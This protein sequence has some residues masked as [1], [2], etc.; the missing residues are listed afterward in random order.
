MIER[1][2]EGRAPAARRGRVSA[3]MRNPAIAAP[4]AVAVLI[5]VAA[6]A[7]ILMNRHVLA[8]WAM[9]DELQ[10]S[11]LAK[12]FAADG[13][14]LFRDQPR[15][16]LSIYPALISPAW[17]AASMKTTYALAKSFNVALMTLAAVPLWFW[18]RR[19]VSP[20]YSVLVVALFLAIPSFVYTGEILTENAYLP[21]VVLALFTLAL[22][23]ERPTV[24]RQ[25][26]ALVLA[27]L[28][29][30]VRVQG[31][32]FALIIPT[33]IVLKV[34]FDLRAARPAARRS[35]LRDAARRWSLSIGALA[36]AAVLYVAY[37][38]V[39]GASLYSG[40]GIY[41]G[42]AQSNYSVRE[43][44]RWVVY[45]F[46]EL[47]FSVGVLPFSALILLTGLAFLRG[48]LAGAAERAF[49]AAATAGVFWTVVEAGVFASDF[50]FRIEERY[51]FNVVPVLLLAL[52]VW[53]DR[54]LPR[55]PALTAA[56][57][58]VPA[59]LLLSVPYTGFFTVALY[60]DTFGLI[61]LWRLTGRLGN[62]AETEVF[63]GLGMLLAGLLFASLPRR[64]AIVAIPVSILAF[65]IA[66]TNSVF[67]TVEFLSAA[68]RHAG[69]LS[70]DP[71]WIDDT[72]GK[73]ARAEF[74]YTSEISDPHTLWQSEF[75]NRS[76]HRVFGVTSQDPSIPDVTAPLD[77]ATGRIEPGLPAGSPDVRPRYVVAASSVDVDG[78]LLARNGS[79]SLYR[80]R[81]P[82]RLASLSSGVMPD[83]W[84]GAS[85]TYTSY[86][87]PP[88][89]KHVDVLLE[90]HGIAGPPP[91][92]VRVSVGPVGGTTVWKT[93][94]GTV[95]NGGGQR[96]SLPVRRAPFQVRLS[97]SPTF[98]P[99][100]FG[101]PDTR[102]LGVRASF[103]V[104]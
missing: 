20:V 63:V 18:A 10:Y 100:Q 37:K 38:V 52:V 71:S 85:A 70:G 42:I 22:A 92:R 80:V 32:V 87:L 84:V 40:F 48:G 59:A 35:V 13:R 89:A 50:A 51:M 5:L 56:A 64:F 36:L 45:H 54:G 104:R 98:S 25:L 30:A 34:A 72:I 103:S 101:S 60:N 28:A 65:F 43:A 61:P 75:W 81:P 83:R 39:Q 66:S 1:R 21:A 102:Q 9:E 26:L 94:T 95:Q 27:A 97:T 8:P 76:V 79:L 23:L 68:T 93:D 24:W 67:G 14:Y 11:D 49:V 44:S 47:A 74:L 29:V 17:F 33:A 3:V 6:V 96:F 41:S 55:P 62:V 16:V 73:N 31:I 77:P 91:A 7:R 58:L 69:G 12:S 90:R 57:A 88:G 15:N 4:A 53:L 86:V 2:L 99:S 78:E 46:G 82:L 19:L